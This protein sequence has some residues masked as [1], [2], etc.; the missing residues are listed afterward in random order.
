MSSI[1]IVGNGMKSDTLFKR[2]FNDAMDVFGA[3]ETGDVLPSET[4][5][6]SRLQVSRTTVRKIVAVLSERGAIT[7]SGR[8]RNL[9][10][11]RG[12][13]RKFPEAETI[14]TSDQVEGRFMQWM[15]RDDTPPGSLINE[16]DLARRFGVA[17]SSIREFLNR[18]QRFGL[19]ERQPHGGWVLK[20][21]TLDFALELF[22][23]R[24]MFEVRSALRFATMPPSSAV[25]RDMEALRV[26]H[27]ALLQHVDRRFHDFSDLDSRF[28]RLVNSAAPNRFIDSFYDVMSLVFHYHYQWN[29]RDERQRNKVAIGEHLALIEALQK[30]KPALIERTCRIHLASAKETMIRSIA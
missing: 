30:R 27:V 8:A 20:G 7:G 10:H 25:W 5:L 14:P 13:L 28:H 2:A 22:E 18:F 16:L 1:H 3:F 26:E 4:E 9:R 15:L 29:K 21:F 11:R 12:A 6:S 23:I 17:T 24:E 19:I